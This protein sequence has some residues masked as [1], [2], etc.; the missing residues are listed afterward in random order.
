[1]N[2]DNEVDRGLA[3]D[4]SALRGA[5]RDV[6]ASDADERN[7]MAA[8]RARRVAAE[9]AS[10]AAERAA[11]VPARAARRWRAP[12]ALAAGA[13]LA[14]VTAVLT[15]RVEQGGGPTLPASSVAPDAPASSRPN[16]AVAA[17]DFTGAF[18]PLAFSS[19]LSVSQSYSV[20]RVRIPLT[21]LT[22][23]YS[24]PLDA[25]I[26]ADLLVGEDGLASGIRFNRADTLFVSTA[27]NERGEPR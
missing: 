1:M 15:L 11:A 7:L 22:P 8:L 19:G 5:L 6:R 13:A 27:S 25:T 12:F 3:A 9:A 26:E 18:Q 16:A 4:L 23:G 24:A 21:A 14:A 2:D 20:V 17:Q 10:A